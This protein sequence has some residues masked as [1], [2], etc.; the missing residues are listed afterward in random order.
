MAKFRTNGNGNNEPD[1]LEQHAGEGF[2][3]I[4][5][6]DISIP[7]LIILQTNSPQVQKGADEYVPGAESG[8]FFNTLTHKLYGREIDL[9]PLVFKKYWL[10]WK[11]N[12]G[13]FVAR[14]EPY[15]IP[16]DKSDFSNWKSENGNVINE[17]FMFFCL[18]EGHLDDGVII[19]SLTSTGIKH[20]KNWNTQIMMTR[21]DSGKRAPYFSSV[22]HLNSVLNKNEQ[23][24]WY[25]IGTKSTNVERKRFINKEEFENY[26][27]P[28]KESVERMQIGNNEF[29]Q[30]EGGGGSEEEVS[31]Y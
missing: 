31:E 26:V 2:E 4:E 10:E 1:F 17:T 14:H 16:V 23:G 20:A 27:L 30:I 7:F 25:Q 29:T 11:P 13:G 3:T 21:L 22:W 5:R 18:I 28:I 9:I 24:S 19:F 15:S 12:R 6:E 8:M